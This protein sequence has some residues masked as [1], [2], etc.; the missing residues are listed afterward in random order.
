MT[1]SIQHKFF[2]S[3]SPAVVWEYLTKAELMA[4]WLMENDF[5]PVVGHDFQFR[6]RPLPNYNFDGII[7]CKV[8]E[9]IPLK[10]LSYSWK[11]GPGN[12]KI[13]LDSVV[14]WTL[15]E[16]ENGAELLLDHSGF[17]EADFTMYSLMSDGWL[18]NIQKIAALIN[19][20]KH[21]TTNS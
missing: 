11:G 6:T 16:K 4:Q 7:Y 5:L 21:G 18:R 13:N 1:K 10:K 20:A 8:L 14:V 15:K 17:K 12:G 2:Y 3:H 9:I 19:T